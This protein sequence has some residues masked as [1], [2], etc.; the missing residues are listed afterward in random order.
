MIE[1]KNENV[2][3]LIKEHDMEQLN[4]MD[5]LTEACKGVIEKS[6]KKVRIDKISISYFYLAYKG[7][8]I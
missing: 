8:D 7:V 5:V 1:T 2:A 6:A 3:E 4:D